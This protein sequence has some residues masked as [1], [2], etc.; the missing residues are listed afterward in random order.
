MLTFEHTLTNLKDLL[1]GYTHENVKAQKLYNDF[2]LENQFLDSKEI[3]NRFSQANEVTTLSAQLN[4]FRLLLI[5]KFMV[6]K[7]ALE[8]IL[9]KA[10]GIDLNEFNQLISDTELVDSLQKLSK[11]R[12]KYAKKLEHATKS[13]KSLFEG[14]HDAIFDVVSKQEKQKQERLF[15]FSYFEYNLIAQNAIDELKELPSLISQLQTAIITA[16]DEG[17]E[18]LK[19]SRDGNAQW[20]EDIDV[21]NIED[22]S[23]KLQSARLAVVQPPEEEEELDWSDDDEP[24]ARPS[25]SGSSSP[26]ILHKHSSIDQSAATNKSDVTTQSTD[27]PKKKPT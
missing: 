11:Q 15:L 5:G 25:I 19:T 6:I 3:G 24:E 13:T 14:M 2:F 8:G 9:T 4:H 27:A 23:Q 26:A 1:V 10:N 12:V 21:S 7:T 20:E 17:L 22:L 18:T 16:R